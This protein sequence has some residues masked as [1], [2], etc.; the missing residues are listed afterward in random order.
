MLKE[1]K[2]LGNNHSDGLLTDK[3]FL[4]RAIEITHKHWQGLHETSNAN[5]ECLALA[6]ALDTI[7]I[8]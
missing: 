7:K 8:Q 2:D 4:A 1:L 3:E 6:A 5:K